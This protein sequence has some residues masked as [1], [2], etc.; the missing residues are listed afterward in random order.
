MLINERHAARLVVF[1]GDQLDEGDYNF[2]PSPVRVPSLQFCGE[3][4][5]GER[6]GARLRDHRRATLSHRLS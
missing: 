3:S 6:G 1:I 5:L 4:C 2:A